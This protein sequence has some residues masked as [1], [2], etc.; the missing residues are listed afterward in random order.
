MKNLE[1]LLFENVTVRGTI[2]KLT[3]H[4]SLWCRNTTLKACIEH[5]IVNGSRVLDHVWVSAKEGWEVQEEIEFSAE[6]IMYSKA[7]G[8]LEYGLKRI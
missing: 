6:V 4:T 7:D 2:Q 8:T 5:V 3:L 1:G